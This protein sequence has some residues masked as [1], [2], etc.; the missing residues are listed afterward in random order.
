MLG[1]SRSAVARWL[2]C[3]NGRVVVWSRSPRNLVHVQAPSFPCGYHSGV[4]SLVLQ[5]DKLPGSGGDDAQSRFQDLTAA[6]HRRSARALDLP[7]RRAET[8]SGAHEVRPTFRV[9][10][11]A[12]IRSI[13][14]SP[15]ADRWIRWRWERKKSCCG[16]ESALYHGGFR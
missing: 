10:A 14:R 5:W 4:R 2:C 1:S 16:A 8:H 7:A 12:V 15:I 11:N 6:R 3:I 13:S 9:M